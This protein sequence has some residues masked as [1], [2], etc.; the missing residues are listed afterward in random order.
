MHPY[1][2]PAKGLTAFNCPHCNAFANQHWSGSLMSHPSGGYSPV[3]GFLISLCNHCQRVA[4]WNGTSMIY[5]N[6]VTAPLPNPDL[7]N[8]IK[9]NFEE[10]RQIANLSPKGAAALLRLVIQKLCV[11]LGEPGKDINKD[12]GSLVKKGLP[13]AVQKALDV[14][15]VIGNEAVH[16]GTIDLNDDP[17]I[18]AK[19][20]EL[21]NIIAAK[22]ITEPKEIDR[23]FEGLP[24]GKKEAIQK[25]DGQ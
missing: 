7:S 5:P 6:K 22:M 4:Y 9:E 2:T 13:S 8:D 3:D 24:Q 10:A 11:H 20:F 14:V 12:I 1:T 23:L 21:V 17:T 19:L 18:T 15:R 16:P 25:R